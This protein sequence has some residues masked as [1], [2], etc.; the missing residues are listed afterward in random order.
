M[1][2]ENT[3]F[4]RPDQPGSYSNSTPSK[5]SYGEIVGRSQNG[6]IQQVRY[7]GYEDF[8]PIESDWRHLE[9]EAAESKTDTGDASVQ[10][11]EASDATVQ[12]DETKNEE[13]P[14]SQATDVPNGAVFDPD[15]MANMM[16]AVAKIQDTTSRQNLMR[17]CSILEA[18]VPLIG[19]CIVAAKMAGL[20]AWML[21]RTTRVTVRYAV[22]AKQNGLVSST[23]KYPNLKLKYS[24]ICRRILWSLT[25]VGRCGCEVTGEPLVS[26][27][28]QQS[29]SVIR[30]FSQ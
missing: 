16:A 4:D 19:R 2:I 26:S 30:R 11:T 22:Y 10:Q 3:R 8:P 17:R 24:L 15:L 14:K 5:Y 28:Q 6:V 27:V 12:Q 9:Y 18:G 13:Q 25:I 29:S 20:L 7:D 21:V 1:Q 23:R